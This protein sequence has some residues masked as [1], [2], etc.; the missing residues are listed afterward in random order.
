MFKFPDLSRITVDGP[1]WS[2]QVRVLR[3]A[4]GAPS[5]SEPL[6]LDRLER[7]FKPFLSA[8]RPRL[9]GEPDFSLNTVDGKAVLFAPLNAD[10]AALTNPDVPLPENYIYSGRMRF[11]ELAGAMSAAFHATI[12]GGSDRFYSLGLIG[13]PVA[14]DFRFFLGGDELT[15]PQIGGRRFFSLQGRPDTWF[16]FRAS[17]RESDGATTIRAKVWDENT[18]EP[19]FQIEI[20][21]INPARPRRGRVGM[22]AS[23]LGRKFFDDLRVSE[24]G[25]NF[26][27]RPVFN[28][29]LESSE[30]VP[31]AITVLCEP[32]DV[33]VGDS[34]RWT[35]PAGG[36][37]AMDLSEEDIRAQ[38]D[39]GQ[40]TMLV[41]SVDP[42]VLAS[43]TAVVFQCLTGSI[44]LDAM[45]PA[46]ESAAQL[47][48]TLIGET[49]TATAELSVNASGLFIRD[50]VRL[51]WK[52]QVDFAAPFLLTRAGQRFLLKLDMESLR[53]N[54][55]TNLSGAWQ[56]LSSYLNPR[57]PL[58]A[59]RRAGDP[60]PNWVTLE[61]SN[62]LAVPRFFR[63]WQTAPWSDPAAEL[64]PFTFSEGQ[65]NVLLSD[66]QPY[67][68]DDPPM[69]LARVLPRLVSIRRNGS[70]LI[71]E[72]NPGE[73][74]AALG[75]S[76]TR[77][78]AVWRE[79]FTLSSVTLAY[80]TVETAR[81]LRG[82][83]QLPTPVWDGRNPL[84]SPYLLAF[85][86]LE[87]GWAQ[88]P[89]PNL[90][91]QIYLD[92]KA[93]VDP[94]APPVSLLEGAVSFSNDQVL[95]GH[96]AEQPWRLTLISG[97]EFRGTWTLSH[98]PAAE[99]RPERFDQSAVELH[100]AAPECVIDGL[101]WL[102]TGKPS[103]EDALPDLTNWVSGLRSV[104]LRTP[105]P[106]VDLFPPP[107]VLEFGGL[108]F[109]AAVTGRRLHASLRGWEWKYFG[110]PV[111]G[112]EKVI[113]GD[114]LE[115]APPLVWRRHAT[116]PMIQALPLTQSITPPNYP[117]PS[118]QLA[119][120]SVPAAGVSGWSFGVDGENGAA[121]FPVLKSPAVPAKEWTELFDL[122][123]A[124]L[125]IPG[126][127]LTPSAEQLTA[128]YRFD[129]PFSDETNAF[130]QLPEVKPD[131]QLPGPQAPP[132]E[133]PKPLVRETLA[134]HWRKLSTLAS[135]AA[136]DAVDAFAIDGQEAAFGNLIE[137]FVWNA[138]PALT[139]DY[140]G[141]LTLAAA[142]VDSHGGITGN[143]TLEDE[144]LTPSP[145]G[146]FH[147][148][149]GSMAAKLEDGK[150]RDQR[151]LQRSHSSES[152]TFILTPVDFRGEALVLATLREHAFLQTG[153]Q[154][155][156][157]WFRDLPLKDGVFERSDAVS[158]QTSGINDPEA[159]SVERNFRNGYEWRMD[160]G[161]LF[162]LEFYPLTLERLETAGDQVRRLEV[163]GR[164][165]LP[166]I[167]AKE[168]EGF[169]NTVR[170]TFERSDGLL[171]LTAINRESSFIEWPLA[172]NAGVTTNEPRLRWRDVS[173]E[174]GQ[175]KIANPALHFF[176]FDE[177]WSVTFS[178]TASFPA[179]LPLKPTDLN[180]R[181]SETFEV[182]ADEAGLFAARVDCTIRIPNVEEPTAQRRHTASVSVDLHLGGG[183]ARAFRSRLQFHLLD[184]DGG[185]G[186][187]EWL[188]GA[189]FDDL[190]PDA[191]SRSAA[192]SGR[193]LQLV[194][195]SHQASA[196]TQL[197][198]GMHVDHAA[199]SPGFAALTFD[200]IPGNLASGFVLRTA[201][202][203]A[204]IHCDWGASLQEPGEES[205][206]RIFGSSAG[207]ISFGYTAELRPDSVWSENLLLNGMLEVKNLVSWPQAMG[208]DPASRTLTLPAAG[209][210][211]SLPHIRHTMRVLFNQHPAP[212]DLLTAGQGRIVFNLK[213]TW[214]FLAVVEHQLAGIGA[215]PKD[216]RWTALQEVRI[217]T[218]AA[219][220]AFL[221]TDAGYMR[222][223]LRQALI[224]E[225]PAGDKMLLVEASAPH[226][227]RQKPIGT[228]A[229]TTLQ[230]LPGGNQQ[231]ILSTP[232]D[233]HSNSSRDW[234]LLRTPFLGRLQDKD[235]D[236]AAGLFQSD[237]IRRLQAA[238]HGGAQR[239]ILLALTSWADTE[240][241]TFQVPAADA[242]QTHRWG[243][244]DP[245]S[246]EE[247]LL[248]LQKPVTEPEPDGLR[249]VMAAL[250]DTP[251]RLSR[252]T[253][254]RRAFD[255]R[256]A[257]QPPFPPL[258]LTGP[259]VW[260]QQSVMAFENAEAASGAPPYGFHLVGLLVRQYLGSQTDAAGRH[261]AVTLIPTLR[262]DEAPVSYVV[263]P[264]LGLRFLPAP[265]A[266]VKSAATVELVCLDGSGGGL[267]PAASR[268]FPGQTD[269]TPWAIGTH[270]LLSPDS[271]IAVLRSREI[272]APVTGAVGAA[273]LTAT[274]SFQLVEGLEPPEVLTRRTF[275]LRAETQELR[276]REAAFGP[277]PPAGL[278][279]FEL[280]P[281][282]VSGMQPVYLPQR[283]WSGL[284]VSV[285]YGQDR[286]PAIGLASGGT[287]WWQAPHYVTQFR[288]AGQNGAPSA[289]LPAQF[290]AQA[291]K[292]LRPVLPASPL[293]AGDEAGWQPVLPGAL[294]YLMVGNRAGSML[295]LRHHLIRQ[296]G[297]DSVVSGS[298][299]V[300]HRV[301]RPVP[302]PEDET[303][304]LLVTT[305]PAD[306]AFFADKNERV[307]LTLS[308]PARGGVSNA[309]DGVLRFEPADH[310]VDSVILTDGSESIEYEAGAR[311]FRPKVADA[312]QRLI[313]KK[314][315][316]DTL[317]IQVRMRFQTLSFLL[318]V[319]DPAA[320]PLP[321]IPFF[322]QFED[323]GYNR[324]LAS[325]SA[326]ASLP[327]RTGENLQTVTLAADRKVYNPDSV[328]SLLW[329]SDGTPPSVATLAILRVDSSGTTQ[330][331][332]AAEELA[333]SV[334]KPIDLAKVARDKNL[335]F[336]P[337][338]AILFRL[339]V[340]DQNINLRVDLTD[341]PVTPVPE[342]AYALLRLTT[343]GERT[344]VECVRFAWSPQA[345]RVELISSDDLKTEVVR[346]R[347]VFQWTD[348]A[349]PGA[350]AIGHY[351]IQKIAPNGSTHF[352]ELPPAVVS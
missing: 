282:Q 141:E 48:T 288:R 83:Q 203:E 45:T 34:F 196:E 306:D 327:L 159:L 101:L 59:S 137:P 47:R 188:D 270:R 153:G 261:A 18:E 275:R 156:R 133:P 301:P 285:V 332:K 217:A 255:S 266:V 99:N 207:N 258:D 334:L 179:L 5:S 145:Q 114:A 57:F 228:A 315:P 317:S 199:G 338:D 80:D 263:S 218:P 116:L 329:Y 313:R 113:P 119:P 127:F 25:G 283:R 178:A 304:R 195:K 81:T 239:Q 76:A 172:L 352:P 237:P 274:Y 210:Q 318:R 27:V 56:D 130:A 52:E 71:V 70:N 348:A 342:A 90:T 180:V 323:P 120:F 176:L 208:W 233:F 245:L 181:L 106:G 122:P 65:F 24:S 184:A 256:R 234:L 319:V 264:Y 189:I 220:E 204:L 125:S 126:V 185:S 169:Q 197:L 41:L 227:I 11:G 107:F 46:G 299:P 154:L 216:H 139:T 221:G 229:P 269:P 158:E 182:P 68:S 294:R 147:I 253:A 331:V 160:F 174:D 163:T 128:R 87:D 350:A 209:E 251:A 183:A 97:G 66:Q 202:V 54:E 232:E 30:F 212:G 286:Q 60:V 110:S 260:R 278:R 88:L 134:P 349:R 55:E 98:T 311:E 268:F 10:A 300:Q 37:S 346:R 173:L 166:L 155:W 17:V 175:L 226:W 104:P 194:W 61:I 89:V 200:V 73:I 152:E 150:L 290:R 340:G 171:T 85:M 267:R 241:A 49:S 336:V 26:A 39:S 231:A 161:Q 272:N 205:D 248:R 265:S 94:A 142:R 12:D 244:I 250:P 243:R 206:E 309:W 123:M 219:F 140:P 165:Q 254:L 112:L 273:P 77:D 277:A 109:Q 236:T 249:S 224:G 22:R 78:G 335:G 291:I 44:N 242:E 149:S 135:L 164:L 262:P 177:E 326:R 308:H 303:V 186:K 13:S 328:V 312:P 344:W 284:R 121:R 95:A 230:F 8:I 96:P 170:L 9:A 51:P 72:A 296:S 192:P 35:R 222:P 214:Q 322:V 310:P 223:D 187:V 343:V 351:A 138:T 29:Q 108:T 252:P 240:A 279:P 84:D 144:V 21:N 3:A 168:Q 238:D 4:D 79:S 86:P 247:N 259:I 298:V 337:G 136:A 215:D 321:L 151:G 16:R 316:G 74:A 53:E 103:A 40:L 307:R 111:P 67:N 148:L 191:A 297:A 167:D 330:E 33:R 43:R 271:P 162:Q 115:T 58:N 93:A 129:L 62:P 305:S 157:F 105:R 211:T 190:I 292:S 276:F 213:G 132:P 302:L 69:S 63:E 31:S 117:S 20:T 225:L 1:F 42:A 257:V 102:S 82:F 91:E 198:P 193:S 146:D 38:L 280:A 2:S 345:S 341:E 281:P 28:Q 19:E 333:A 324:R 6:T 295:A 118:R 201:F 320:P 235:S 14:P 287:R 143:F 7:F 293:P 15:L 100:M 75:Y 246:L 64:P 50:R 32:V 289:G 131:T 36:A 339:A 92:S 314:R 124:S 23:G 347:G 325:A